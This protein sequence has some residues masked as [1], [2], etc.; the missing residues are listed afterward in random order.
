[1]KDRCYFIFFFSSRRRHTRCSRDWSSDVCFR[2]AAWL[3]A[4]SGV[5]T[6]SLAG[7]PLDVTADVLEASAEDEPFAGRLRLVLRNDD[8]R[9][10]SQALLKAGAEIRV[11]AGYVTSSGPQAS[12]GPAYWTDG[13]ELTSGGGA[14]AA[15]AP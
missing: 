14:A 7:S 6:A 10:T 2:S 1:M 12:A 4:P 8:G 3:C 15:G 9:Y 13:V 11:S 5:W